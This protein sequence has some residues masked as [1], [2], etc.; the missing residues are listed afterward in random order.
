MTAQ[1]IVTSALTLIGR[2]GQGRT[3]G[4]VESATAFAILQR[5]MESLSLDRTFIF[6]VRADV[7]LLVANTGKYTIG[8]G[9]TLTGGLRP[10]FIE[11]ANMVL[12]TEGASDRRPLKIINSM[13]FASIATLADVS[14]I[15][16]VLYDDYASPLSTIQLHPIPST[17]S[18]LELYTWQA[19]QAFVSLTDTFSMP[20]GYFRFLKAALAIEMAPSFQLPVQPTLAKEYNDAKAAIVARNLNLP[21]P[22]QS[23]AAVAPP[24]AAPN[25]AMTP[26]A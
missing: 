21:S 15:P 9:G 23:M 20:P 2:L 11:S 16:K 19:L 7:Y 4:G 26:A 1:D 6:Q 25:P 8:P 3:P 12:T 22:A 5:L 13:E 17:N 24:A 18:S 14:T 10:V